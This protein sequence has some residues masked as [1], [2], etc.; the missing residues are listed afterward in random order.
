MVTKIANVINAARV[1]EN[2]YGSGMRTLVNLGCVLL[3]AVM[4]YDRPDLSDIFECYFNIL[5]HFYFFI[6]GSFQYCIMRS[7]AM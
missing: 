5:C 3:M 4:C 6:S 7:K 1:V 2:K